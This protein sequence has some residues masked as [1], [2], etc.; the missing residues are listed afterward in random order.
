MVVGYVDV[1][2]R[3]VEKGLGYTCCFLPEGMETRKNISLTPLIRR[4]GTPVVRSTWF[5]YSKEK[6]RPPALEQFIRYVREEL[7]EKY[8]GAFHH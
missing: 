2:L 1:A 8:E 6:R 3:L 5:V 7:G 4:D